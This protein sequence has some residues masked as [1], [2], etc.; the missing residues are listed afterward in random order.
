[1]SGF[2]KFL[3]ANL[4]HIFTIPIVTSNGDEKFS[5]TL[6][7][8]HNKGAELCDA[9]AIPLMIQIMDYFRAHRI[10]WWVHYDGTRDAWNIFQRKYENIALELNES[11]H[12]VPSSIIPIVQEIESDQLAISIGKQR[13][14]CSTCY[15]VLTENALLKKTIRDSNLTVKVAKPSTPDIAPLIIEWFGDNFHSIGVGRGYPRKKL[16]LELSRHLSQRYGHEAEI[17]PSDKLW[18]WVVKDVIK[19]GSAQYRPFR[20]WKRNDVLQRI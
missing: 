4:T 7:D 15:K 6:I 12:V 16:R 3:K 9:M 13:T 5:G 19:D 17:S 11:K 2:K 20:L 14:H 18:K 8:A 10:D 1:M